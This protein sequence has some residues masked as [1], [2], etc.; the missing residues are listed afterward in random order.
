MYY[1]TPAAQLIHSALMIHITDPI[2]SLLHAFSK[3]L[4][5]AIGIIEIIFFSH[6]TCHR[7]IK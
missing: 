4:N 7:K 3:A 5:Q 1:R 2:P 6:T